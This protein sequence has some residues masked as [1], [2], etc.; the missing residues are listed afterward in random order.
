MEFYNKIMLWFWLSMA[1]VSG[2]AVTF[3]CFTEGFDRWV[4][5]YVVPVLAFL[6]YVLRKFMIKRMQKHLKYLEE[7]NK[8]NH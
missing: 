1:I 4:F 6:M 7:K 2:I 3:M 5:Y 8:G